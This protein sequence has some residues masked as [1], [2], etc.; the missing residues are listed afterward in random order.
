MT[1]SATFNVVATLPSVTTTTEIKQ[2][3]GRWKLAEKRI[4]I[5]DYLGKFGASGKRSAKS[6]QGELLFCGSS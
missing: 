6:A 2:R 3:T 1:A 4:S 5:W